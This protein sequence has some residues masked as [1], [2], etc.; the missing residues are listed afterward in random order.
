MVFKFYGIYIKDIE[1][2]VAFNR[3]SEENQENQTENK[4]NNNNLQQ[5][6]QP[7]EVKK[8]RKNQIL[9]AADEIKKLE[10]KTD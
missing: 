2:V 4:K 3:V 9:L 8:T 5:N 6:Q 1:N 7:K 10:K